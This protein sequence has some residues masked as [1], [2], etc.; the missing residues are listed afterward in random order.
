MILELV[1]VPF[2]IVSTQL[3][4][5]GLLGGYSQILINGLVILSIGMDKLLQS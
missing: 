1:L 4:M 3:R 2:A 5:N